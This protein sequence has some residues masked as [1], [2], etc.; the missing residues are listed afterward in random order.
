M[1][2]C[3][4]GLFATVLMVVWSAFDLPQH[5][6]S[7]PNTLLRC[8]LFLVEGVLLSLGSARMWRSMRDAALSETWHRQLVETAAEGIWVHDENGVIT[9]ANARMAEMLGVAGG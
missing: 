3:G 7:L 8:L 9:Y 4:P 6:I 2:R 1:G 5:G